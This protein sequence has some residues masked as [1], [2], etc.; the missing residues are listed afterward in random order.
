[1]TSQLCSELAK[2]LEC[3]VIAG[4]PERLTDEE[5]QTESFNEDGSPEV[6]SSSKTKTVGAN[7]AA[8]YGPDGEWVG[9]YRKTHLFE[10]DKTW[11]KA[12][13]TSSTPRM[14]GLLP[15][16]TAGDGF[17][18]FSLPSPLRTM[19][20][21]ICMDLNPQ[22]PEWRLAEGPYEIADYCIS[23]KANLLILLNAWLDSGKETEEVND[24]STLNYWA[25]RLRPL[26]TDGSE[27]SASEDDTS[28]DQPDSKADSEQR[29]DETVVV[30]CN[31]SGEENGKRPIN[32]SS[33]SL[34]ERSIKVKLLPV[35]QLSS[36]WSQ[37]QDA[38][39]YST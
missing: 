24:W 36:A 17:A 23:K 18:T 6:E 2:K 16:G 15:D 12:G 20:L 26:W 10:T 3:Y 19:G 29:G 21:G 4:Y 37:D 35:V 25:A 32:S 9:G 39:N 8:M 38:L 27:G 34:T 33:S 5:L 30:I 28:E 13:K 31:R 11:A 22:I 1:M 14:S 7:S